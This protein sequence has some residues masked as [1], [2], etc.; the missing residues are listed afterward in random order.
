MTAEELEEIE[1]QKSLE[2][3]RKKIKTLKRFFRA[4]GI[5]SNT[6]YRIEKNNIYFP[7]YGSYRNA[8]IRF[9]SKDY[10][11]FDETRFSDSLAHYRYETQ[12]VLKHFQKLGDVGIYFDDAF[13][14]H[15]TS[16]FRVCIEIEGVN[17]YDIY[18]KIPHIAR[19][20]KIKLALGKK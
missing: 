1:Y 7:K 8:N 5:K 17:L 3:D 20:E 19:K 16:E 4:L 15:Y 18:D 13:K 9:L 10:I 14:Y 6:V 2:I 11:K 12:K